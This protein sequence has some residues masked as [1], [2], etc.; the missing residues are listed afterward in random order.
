MVLKIILTKKVLRHFFLAM[1]T[2]VMEE[3]NGLYPERVIPKFGAS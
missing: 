1:S 2:M 3:E